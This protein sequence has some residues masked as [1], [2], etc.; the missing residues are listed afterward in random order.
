[1]PLQLKLPWS[2]AGLGPEQTAS[3]AQAAQLATGGCHIVHQHK[4]EHH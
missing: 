2:I 4:L 1:M 3:I